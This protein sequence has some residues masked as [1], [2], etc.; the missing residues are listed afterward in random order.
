MTPFED[1]AAVIHVRKFDFLAV[2]AVQ[3]DVAMLLRQ[4]VKGLLHVEAVVL[5]QRAQQMEVINVATIPSSDG[6]FSET[7]LWVEYHPVFIKKLRDTQTVAA[8]ARTGRVVERKQLGFKLIN[9]MPA[10]GTGVAGREQ[11]LR[12]VT[13]HGRD[14]CHAVGQF[15]RSLEGFREPQF[16]VVT[17][18]ES[19][20][21]DIDSV[22]PFFIERRH[23]VEVNDDAIDPYPDESGGPHLLENV[24]MFA[25]A[26][27]HDR[28]KEHQ[29]AALG[30]C[31]HRVHHLGHGLGFQCDA[32]SGASRIP[33]PG[34]QKPQVVVDFGDGAHGGTGVVRR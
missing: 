29:L 33:N 20:D 11:R 27:A 23:I 16:E 18:L 24:Q 19:I 17:D 34:K 2:T 13:L 22:L 32:M 28:G 4:F 25:F 14:G 10:A 6:A 30:Q 8:M 9:G 1:G 31:H 7:G 26:V 21:D 15:Q 12:A 3:N 5:R